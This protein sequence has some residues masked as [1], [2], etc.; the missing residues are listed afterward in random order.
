MLLA[1][2]AA[3]S[4]CLLEPT[5]V[6][7]AIGTDVPAVV[8]LAIT[9]RVSRGRIAGS[10]PAMQRWQRASTD[11]GASVDGGIQ[12]PASFSVVPGSGPRDGPVFVDLEADAGGVILRRRVSFQFVPRETLTLRVFLTTRCL[13][14]TTGCGP[15]PGPCTVLRSCE[16]QSRTCGDQ[17]ECVDVP[18]SLSNDRDGSFGDTGPPA[19]GTYGQACCAVGAQ[20]SDPL[21]CVANRCQRCTDPAESCCSGADLRANGAVCVAVSSAGPE[22]GTCSDGVCTRMLLAPAGIVATSESA[23]AIAVSWA[24]VSGAAT[25]TVETSPDAGFGAPTASLGIATTNQSIGGLDA[26]R[27]YHARVRAIAADGELGPWSDVASA[28]T[29]LGAPG[30]PSVAVTIAT[31]TRLTSSCCWVDLPDPP[32]MYYYA[33]GSASSRGPAGT[34]IQYRFQAQYTGTSTV[35][36]WTGWMGPDA[37]MTRPLDGYG[38]RFFAQARCVGA[39][40]V[41]GGSGTGSGCRMRSGAGC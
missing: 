1:A 29:A 10:D 33:Q 22:Q 8:P 20:C 15:G 13:A 28:I 9:A 3:Q 30:A 26:G 40:A 35:Y 39:D 41:S 38:V 32:G 27:R 14:L 6:I 16:E 24:P 34:S 11:G 23:S 2:I 7:I 5:E 37:Y 25:Y 36:G 4:A 31:G 17:G 21:A 12:L 19:C 18:T